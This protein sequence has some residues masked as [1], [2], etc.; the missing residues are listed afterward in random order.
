MGVRDSGTAI[1]VSVI[2]WQ[3]THGPELRIFS[4][5]GWWNRPGYLSRELPRSPGVRVGQP[6]PGTGQTFKRAATEGPAAGDTFTVGR[7][8]A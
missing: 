3:Y 5:D 7:P 1:A 4:I 8:A 6:L 2:A